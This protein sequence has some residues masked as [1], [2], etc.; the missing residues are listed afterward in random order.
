[1]KDLTWVTAIS[2]WSM[3]A[4]LSVSSSTCSWWGTSSDSGPESS[5]GWGSR[6]FT[7]LVM[8][9][10]SKECSW[11]WKHHASFYCMSIDLVHLLLFLGER[12][13]Y[14][15]VGDYMHF[16][17]ILDFCPQFSLVQLCGMQVDSCWFHPHHFLLPNDQDAV[18]IVSQIIVTLLVSALALSLWMWYGTPTSLMKSS[19]AWCA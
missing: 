13:P 17:G 10:V 11:A 7:L 3:A 14:V 4:L 18:F 8:K 5:T 1:M 6:W 12:L 2:S 15:F 19:K 16:S 9:V